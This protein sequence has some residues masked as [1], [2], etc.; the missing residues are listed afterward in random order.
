MP[1]SE[2]QVVSIFIR[3]IPLQSTTVLDA[4][5]TLLV[6]T[7]FI[8]APSRRKSDVSPDR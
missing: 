4:T 8:K 3:Q 6:G 2:G 5:V 7:R 1:V